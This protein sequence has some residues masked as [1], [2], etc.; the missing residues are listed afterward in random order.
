[1]KTIDTLLNADEL[2]ESGFIQK[3]ADNFGY[4]HLVERELERW[5]KY[6]PTYYILEADSKLNFGLDFQIWIWYKADGIQFFAQ[7]S[8]GSCSISN[9]GLRRV[10]M[11][12]GGVVEFGE[13]YYAKG[14][15]NRQAFRD[16][17]EAGWLFA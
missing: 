6:N 11:L 2:K 16:L 1:M 15:A 5:A 14:Q 17:S 3:Y 12:P 4:N 7:M 10:K 8:L 9:Q 13:D